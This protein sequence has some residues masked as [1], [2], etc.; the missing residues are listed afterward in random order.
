MAMSVLN[1]ALAFSASA[2]S[3]AHGARVSPLT[4]IIAVSIDIAM[5]TDSAMRRRDRPSARS[6]V[7]SE[8]AASCPSPISAPITAAIGNRV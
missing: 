5:A 7:S 2:F 4:T 1:L 3:C 8:V 6:A